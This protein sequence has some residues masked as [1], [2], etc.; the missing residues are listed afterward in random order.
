MGRMTEIDFPVWAFF[1]RLDNRLFLAGAVGFPEVLRLVPSRE[2]GREEL[3]RNLAKVLEAAPLDSLHRRHPAGELVVVPLSLAIAPVGDNAGWR[4]PLPLH[5]DTLAWEHGTDAAVSVIPELGITVLADR[6]DQRDERLAGEVRAALSRGPALTLARLV[7]LQRT[8]PTTVERLRVRFR[9]HTAK[10]RAQ[11][12]ERQQQSTPS[13]LRQ[14]ATNLT[15]VPVEPAYGIDALLTQLAEL[16]SARQPRS[17]LLVGPSG[18]GK[19]AA[20]RELARRRAEFHLGATPFWATSGARL[21]AGMSGF[22]MWQDRCRQVIREASRRKA[23]V[24]LGNLVELTQV[25][26]SEHNMLG[27]GSFL[28]PAIARGH[29]LAIAEV[30]A[31]QLSLLEREEPHLVAVFQP[32]TVAESGPEEGRA[33]LRHGAETTPYAI[34]KTL[35]DPVLDVLDR[36]HRRYTT[37]SAY[38]GRPLRFLRGLLEDHK[39]DAALRPAQV[40]D[41]FT[42]E[43]GL[44]RVLI[45]PS[46]RLDL[47]RLR[48]WL[49]ARVIDQPEAVALVADLVATAKAGMA[50]PRRPIASLLFIGPTGVGKTEMAKALAEYLFGSRERMTRFDMSEYGDPISV[51]RLVGFGFH[52]GRGPEAGGEGLLTAKVREQPFGV[53]LFDEFEKAHPQFFD[54]LLQVLGEGRLTDAAGRLA[55]FTNTVIILTSNLGAESYQQGAFG[56]A[57][58]AGDG[59]AHAAA[60]REHFRAAVE[61]FL[62]PEMYNRIDRIVPFGPLG[63]ATI[64]RIAQRHLSQLEERDGVRNRG[65]TFTVGPG[66]AAH[67]ARAGFDA[68][69]GARPLLRAVE[70]ELLAPLA[71]RMNAYSAEQALAVEVRLEGDRLDIGVKARTDVSGRAMAAGTGPAGIAEAAGRCVELRR[72][73]QALERCRSVR[74]LQNDLFRLEKEQEAFEKLQRNHARRMSLLASAPEEVRRRLAIKAPRVG[75][76]EQ[77]RMTR[78]G[79][80]RDLAGRLRRL[81]GDIAGVEDESLLALYAT[82]G[83]EAFGVAELGAALTPLG[84][85]FDELL[86][87]LYCREFP[88][89]DHVTLGLFAEDPG[90]LI[91]LTAAYLELARR[92]NLTWRLAAYLLPA[93][94]RTAPEPA[95]APASAPAADAAEERAQPPRQFWRRDKLIVAATARAPE[96]VVLVRQWVDDAASFLADPP[97]RLPGMVLAVAGPAAAPRLTPEEGLHLL[98]A[99]KLRQ[100]AACLVDT[101]E[102]QVEVYVPPHD[103]TRKGALGTQDRRRTYDRGLEALDDPMLLVRVPWRSRALS[104]ALDEAIEKHFRRCLFALL[105]EE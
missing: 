96:R 73:V 102:V 10:A 66:V 37:Y 30:T 41:A 29:L 19:T 1:Q 69:Y 71:Q 16:L 65:V 54:L 42:R 48:E 5:F 44:P 55:D 38:P 79:E 21:V 83:L 92:R 15:R 26:K 80:L 24:H 34:R 81:V 91:E 89:A 9:F 17:V 98:K 82:G 103:I 35:P 53:L 45:D 77:A 68:R 27:I 90:W 43:T 4:E 62:R 47:D 72:Q 95:P 31:E 86:L 78:L 105:L 11:S 3:S 20:V 50:R 12:A 57:G 40:L 94:A 28:R 14:V 7:G 70:R 63:P 52:A 101:S 85:S 84:R 13:V 64:E 51:Q 39:A 99:S 75:P 6:A 104:E 61:S 67:L 18:A 23:V 58:A 76:A 33:I 36:L 93:G 49:G 59:T 88:Q 97:P 46:E 100:P 22:G 56:F 60:A 8:G 2:R 87:E 32:L 74:T 25:G